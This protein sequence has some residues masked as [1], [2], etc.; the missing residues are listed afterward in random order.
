MDLQQNPKSGCSFIK[1]RATLNKVILQA[2]YRSQPKCPNQTVFLKRLYEV[3]LLDWTILPLDAMNTKI[4]LLC[5]LYEQF[6][7]LS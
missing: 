2:V 5:R 3:G 4:L 6:T 1:M 7:H